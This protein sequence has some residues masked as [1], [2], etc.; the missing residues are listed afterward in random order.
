MIKKAS[1]AT[2]AKLTVLD[3][4]PAY[5]VREQVHLKQRRAIPPNLY[6][7]KYHYQD[8][9]HQTIVVVNSRDCGEQ[10]EIRADSRTHDPVLQK[11]SQY[12]VFV[13][14]PG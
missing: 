1:A 6:L 11:Y 8:V 3:A 9:V 7:N 4:D 2:R 13:I 5:E 12:H 10:K 14:L